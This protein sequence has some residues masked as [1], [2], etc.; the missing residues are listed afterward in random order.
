MSMKYSAMSLKQILKSVGLS[1]RV[2]NVN[3]QALPHSKRNIEHQSKGQSKHIKQQV[4]ISVYH[5]WLGWA[6][7][8]GFKLKSWPPRTRNRPKWRGK[9]MKNLNPHKASGPDDLPA[10]VFKDYYNILSA[11]LCLLYQA[12]VL[13]GKIPNDWRKALI[14][15]I[16]KKEI[17]PPG[18]L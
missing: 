18:Q 11:P 15:P 16:Y 17:K 12:S 3:H 13:Q 14:S 6:A 1:L 9:L 4:H 10:R 7:R 8:H 5:R 2:R